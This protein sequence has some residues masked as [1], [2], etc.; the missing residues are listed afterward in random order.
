MIKNLP[1]EE[2]LRTA[3]LRSYFR[4]WDSIITGIIDFGQTYS[5]IEPFNAD[6]GDGWDEERQ[7]YVDAWQPELHAA[8]AL[9]QNANELALKSRIAAVSPYLLLL[10]ADLRFSSIAQ[11]V[12]FS[13]LRTLDAVDL[14]RAVN[15]LTSTPVNAAY[16]ERY[17]ELRS[18]RNKYEHLGDTNTPLDPV[19]LLTSMAQTYFDLWP[20]RMWLKD[21]NE[22]G[23]FSRR[24]FFS[25][26]NWSHTQ[27]TLH[28]FEYDREYIPNSLFKRIFGTKKSDVKFACPDC[29]SDWAVT[30]WGPA[31][32]EVRVAYYDSEAKS[33][34]CLVCDKSFAANQNTC[35][36]E[37]CSSPFETTDTDQWEIFCF[38]C[39]EK[40]QHQ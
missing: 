6:A 7:A 17:G 32:S 21:R 15:T 13:E 31:A 5:E 37:H 14:P 18:S 38:G 28:C 35:L 27:E 16:V 9:L 10:N 4:A 36:S 22:A 24:G 29:M 34:H 40:T 3:A 33:M 12:D 19:K 23:E 20:N 39:G 2:G 30:R 11:D 26:K 8:Q 1:S 25:D